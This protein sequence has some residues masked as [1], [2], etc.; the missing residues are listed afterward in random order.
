MKFFFT[1]GHYSQVERL[2]NAG[3][4][5]E[6][7]FKRPFLGVG[8]GGFSSYSFAMEG[9]E[10]FN[11]PH[12]ILLEV[13]CEMGIFGFLFFFLNVFFGFKHLIRLNKVYS[14]SC[15]EK[16]FL[17]LFVFTFLNSLT[18]GHIANPALFAFIGSAFA[19]GETL[20]G[21]VNKLI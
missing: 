14:H 10:Q 11:Y 17:S 18:C 1:S 9:F 2:Q 3:I 6:L 20:R 21:H 13:L 15:L 4:A 16:V 8:I 7:F 12:N 19:V 5:L